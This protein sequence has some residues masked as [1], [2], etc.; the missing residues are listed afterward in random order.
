M[1][2][3]GY[4]S[5]MQD[6]ICKENTV[7]R[8]GYQI[9]VYLAFIIALSHFYKNLVISCVQKTQALLTWDILGNIGLSLLQI[10][11]SD[12]LYSNLQ[13]TEHHY[14]CHKVPKDIGGSCETSLSLC[15]GSSSGVDICIARQQSTRHSVLSKIFGGPNSR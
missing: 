15:S 13:F 1:L 7:D 8:R 3:K 10:H 9:M 14:T 5:D 12:H 11:H 6:K 2:V 4:K